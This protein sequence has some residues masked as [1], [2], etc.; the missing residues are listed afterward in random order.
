MENMIY[1]IAEENKSQA[2]DIVEQYQFISRELLQQELEKISDLIYVEDLQLD[3]LYCISDYGKIR[4]NKPECF[5]FTCGYY[6]GKD[7]HSSNLIFEVNTAWGQQ[8]IRYSPRR[9][10]LIEGGF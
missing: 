7:A 9:L 4:S 8:D 6:R 2:F 5:F 1:L 3:K 10:F